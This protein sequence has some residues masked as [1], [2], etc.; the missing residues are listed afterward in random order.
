VTVHQT[1]RVVLLG[2][3][4]ADEGKQELDAAERLYRLERY[5]QPFEARYSFL[6]IFQKRR[7]AARRLSL[8]LP[9]SWR[10]LRFRDPR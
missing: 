5:E 6:R 1:V 7:R 3:C 8:P 10:R 4:M 2:G 9:L